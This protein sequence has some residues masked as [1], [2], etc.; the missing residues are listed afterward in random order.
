MS[1][2]AANGSS[3]DLFVARSNRQF[4]LDQPPMS[5]TSPEF[6]AWI[7]AELDERKLTARKAAEQTGVNR[8]TVSEMKRGIVPSYDTLV[9]FA[10]GI[11]LSEAE[12]LRQAG[13]QIVEE[14]SGPRRFWQGLRELSQEFGE[15]SLRVA[16]AP[17][18]LPVWQADAIL[19]RLRSDLERKR[20]L[21]LHHHEEGPAG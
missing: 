8:T 12:I 21:G 2:P 1:E 16:E 5:N 6:G 17:E 18:E 10:A 9:R 13:R 3:E 19:A 7:T 4:V 15:V 14:E 20:R 11:G